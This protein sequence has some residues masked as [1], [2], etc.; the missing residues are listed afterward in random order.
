MVRYSYHALRHVTGYG[1][2]RTPYPYVTSKRNPYVT[3][4]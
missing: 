1:V 4:P 3:V 2:L